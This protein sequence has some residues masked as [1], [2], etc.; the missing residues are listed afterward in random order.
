MT[1]KQMSNAKNEDLKS[2]LVT[3]IAKKE[4]LTN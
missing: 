2:V 4:W 3:G 1:R